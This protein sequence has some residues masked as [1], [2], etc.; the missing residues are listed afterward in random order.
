MVS[1]SPRPLRGVNR[2][3]SNSTHT[4]TDWLLGDTYR[5]FIYYW[6]RVTP[7]CVCVC[8]ASRKGTEVRQTVELLAERK[9]RDASVQ[10]TSDCHSQ[11][12]AQTKRKKRRNKPTRKSHLLLL[13][14]ATWW[15][16]SR[17]RDVVAQTAAAADYNQSAPLF[18]P[19]LTI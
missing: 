11:T 18:F 4:E 12:Q 14:A 5:R 3:Q 7:F 16:M 15:W 9:E 10:S 17:E 6:H 19:L 8:A 13:D 2:L 1:S